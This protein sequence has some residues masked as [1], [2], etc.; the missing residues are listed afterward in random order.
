[1][2]NVVVFCISFLMSASLSANNARLSIEDSA[3]V[4]SFA[5]LAEA[6]ALL[7]DS[8][9]NVTVETIK[10]FPRGVRPRQYIKSKFLSRNKTGVYILV[11]MS[12]RKLVLVPSRHSVKSAGLTKDKLDNIRQQM[13]GE[14]RDHNYDQGL[15][16]GIGEIVSLLAHTNSG[17]QGVHGNTSSQSERSASISEY[18]FPWKYLFIIALIFFAFRLLQRFLSNRRSTQLSNQFSNQPN[19]PNN[20]SHGGFGGSGILQGI[21][22]GIAATVAGRWLYDKVFNTSA[23]AS[24]HGA[25]NMTNNSEHSGASEQGST[26]DSLPEATADFDNMSGDFSTGDDWGSSSGGD[27]GSWGGDDGGDMGGD[28]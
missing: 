19:Q 9:I 28:W 6:E 23:Q 5:T 14:F 26:N 22:G 17:S 2:L 1:M 3:N 11:S 20:P 7:K 15:L 24:E 21:L 16:V 10:K 18:S 8:S 27:S 4:F 13:L 12:P 25:E